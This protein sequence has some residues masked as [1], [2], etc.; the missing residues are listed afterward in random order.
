MDRPNTHVWSCTEQTEL[1]LVCELQSC[2]DVV[3]IKT[4]HRPDLYATAVNLRSP[5]FGEHVFQLV[6]MHDRRL[7]WV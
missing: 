3:N 1:L 6:A 5:Q 4:K 7:A 2:K